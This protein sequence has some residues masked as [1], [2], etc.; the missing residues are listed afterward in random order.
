MTQQEIIEACA[1]FKG[2]HKIDDHYDSSWWRNTGPNSGYTVCLV[3]DYDPTADTPTGRE[4]ANELKK[5]LMEMNLGYGVGWTSW[6][7]VWDATIYLERS[8]IEGESDV[9]GNAA[10]AKAVAKLQIEQ[11]K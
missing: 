1:R 3:R 8:E 9:C 4:Q 11:E 5:K 10:L 6:L 7:K 2:W